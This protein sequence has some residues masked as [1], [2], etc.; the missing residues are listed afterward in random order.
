MFISNINVNLI[1]ELKTDGKLQS[2]DNKFFIDLFEEYPF[3]VYKRVVQYI[4]DTIQVNISSDMFLL[5]R[6]FNKI[7]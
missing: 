6:R 7:L 4:E 3:V 5:L 2:D 1:F